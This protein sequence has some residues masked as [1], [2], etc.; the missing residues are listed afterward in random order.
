[1]RERVQREEALSF[2]LR[3]RANPFSGNKLST[4]YGGAFNFFRPATVLASV[5]FSALFARRLTIESGSFFRTLMAVLVRRDLYTI[6]VSKLFNIP[7]VD[8][9]KRRFYRLFYNLQLFFS[10]HKAHVYNITASLTSK[11]CSAP[12]E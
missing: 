4:F 10:H 7:S 9:R 11:K 5:R 8:H 1:M 3:T 6:P 12:A 2:F